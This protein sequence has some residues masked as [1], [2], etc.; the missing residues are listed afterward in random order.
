MSTDLH[1]MRTAGGMRPADQPTVDALR[2]IKTGAHFVLTLH[3]QKRDRSLRQH[4]LFMS[5]LAKVAE[6][7]GKWA[8]NAALLTVLKIAL[9][10]CDVVQMLDGENTVVARSIA[11]DRLS[12]T[13]FSEFFRGAIQILES[14]V[15]PD[16]AD[17]P[18]CTE[19]FAMLD[20]SPQDG[21][22][23]RKAA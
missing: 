11:F 21:D 18:E 20:G 1:F 12:Q 19:I 2:K 9:G 13:K 14:E 23:D 16:I 22:L 6:A 3:D 5:L 4:R 17:M 7:T 15:F 8:N 10:H